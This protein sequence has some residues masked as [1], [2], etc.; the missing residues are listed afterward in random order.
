MILVTTGTG[1]IP[2]DR[3][4]REVDRLVGEGCLGDLPVHIQVGASGHE[5]VHCTWSRSL[6]YGEMVEHVS[7]AKL[8]IAHGGVGTMLLCHRY[9]VPE[10]MVPRRQAL[11]ENVDD[12]QVDFA[13]YV[14]ELGLAHMAAEDD[15]E[16][17]IRTALAGG[18]GARAEATSKPL[19]ETLRAVFRAWES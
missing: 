6:D 15:L 1:D 19:V 12:H 13:E 10:V 2:F 18:D 5:P 11:G 7:R 17:V 4:V 8:V 3:L 16:A 14:A 9:G